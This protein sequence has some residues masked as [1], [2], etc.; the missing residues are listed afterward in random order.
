[1][2]RNNKNN[3]QLSKPQ[4]GQSLVELALTITILLT[5]LAGAFDI[6]SAFLDFIAMRDAAQEGAT[7]ASIFP[8]DSAGIIQ[9]VQLS[10]TVP[11][12]FSIFVEDCN[13]DSP[14]GI[15]IEIA[16]EPCSGNQ[17][18]ITVRYLYRLI[19]P[20]VGGFLGTQDIPLHA[21]VTNEIMTTA[22]E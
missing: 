5:L 8:T 12:N 11:V 14:N 18:K 20:F 9:S 7:Y 2:I 13:N 10:S 21:S 15:C 6:G 17:V 16:D 1:M 19:V 4:K 22:C 3:E